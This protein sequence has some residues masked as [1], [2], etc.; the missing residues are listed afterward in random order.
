MLTNQRSRFCLTKESR[1]EKVLKSIR[2]LKNKNIQSEVG[3]QVYC[4]IN[5][6]NDQRQLVEILVL[7]ILSINT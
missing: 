1:G 5:S 3:F 6:D 7:D 2:S 4:H